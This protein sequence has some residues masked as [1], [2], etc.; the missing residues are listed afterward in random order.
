MKT[1]YVLLRQLRK[2]GFDLSGELIDAKENMSIYISEKDISKGVSTN[3]LKCTAAQCIQ[4]SFDTKKVA[5]FLT[6]CYV[7]MP[8]ESNISR[9]IVPPSL[10][11]HIVTPQDTGGNP[12][13]GWYRL[14]NPE[15]EYRLSAQRAG[16]QR[17]QE[18]RNQGILPRRKPMDAWKQANQYARSIGRWSTR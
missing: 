12:I 17:L 3:P 5:M 8:D 10:R 15:G 2:L 18:K 4:R 16:W 6:T 9:Y 14:Q 1:S 7:Q 13:A 11:K